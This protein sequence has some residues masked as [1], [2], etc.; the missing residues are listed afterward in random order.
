VAPLN[1]TTLPYNRILVGLAVAAAVVFGASALFSGRADA[2]ATGAVAAPTQ[3]TGGLSPT[4]AL[5][6]R[7][8]APPIPVATTPAQ[9]SLRSAVVATARSQ[10][11]VA[12]T[13]LGSN[14][15]IYGPCEQW[16]ADFATWVWRHAGIAAVGRIAYVP[17][18]VTWAKNHGR[19]KAGPHANP[20]P[21]DIADFS[22]IH[23]GVVERV[24][25][26]GAI[27]IVAGNTGAMA[28]ARRGPGDP[29]DG[30]SMGPGPIVGYVSATPLGTAARATATRPLVAETP[31]RI[32][33]MDPQD[34]DPRAAA[35]DRALLH[36]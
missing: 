7:R 27:T 26:S 21:G 12:E 33:R 31:A 13:P 16:C 17:N 29:A 11:G 28:V 4:A 8:S 35:R 18:L 15:T 36:R 22:G 9:T 32:A 19:W 6:P 14:C 34:H 5:P 20:Q 3:A 24:L 25:R 2:A 1:A 23:V 30:S 10:L